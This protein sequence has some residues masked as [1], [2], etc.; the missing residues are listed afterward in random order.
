LDMHEDR[1]NEGV[2]VLFCASMPTKWLIDELHKQHWGGH[3]YIDMGSVFDV[4]VGRCSRGYH[5]RV[6]QRMK[7]EGK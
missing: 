5:K 7:D 6:L 3:T 4:Y 1:S 2:V